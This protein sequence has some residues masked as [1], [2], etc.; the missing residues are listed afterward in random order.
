MISSNA[1]GHRTRR[2]AGQRTVALI[3]ATSLVLLAGCW[4]VSA[5]GAEPA[6]TSAAVMRTSTPAA[7]KKDC[8]SRTAAGVTSKQITVAATVIDLMGGSL[9]N[10]SYGIPSIADQEAGWK[11]V[12]DNINKNGGMGCRQIVLQLYTVNPIDSSAAQQVCLNIAAAHPFIV[13]DPGVLTEAN[14]SDCLPA[15]KVPLASEY[16][17][18]EQLD[19]YHPYYLQIGDL[20]EDILRNGVLGLKQL[21]YFE[22][23]KGFRKIGVLYHTC[24]TALETA[25]VGALKA[26]AIP[27]HDIV[28]YNLGCPN[29]GSDTPASMEQAVLN[30][31]NAGVT[32]VMMLEVTEG[33]IF[34]QVAEQQNFKPQYL[35]AEDDAATNVS[36]GGNAPNP[37]NYNNAVDVLGSAYGEQSTPGYKPSGGAQKC[38]ALLAAAGKPSVYSQTSGYPGVQC[39]Y[40]WFAQALLSHATTFEASAFPRD[41]RAMGTVDFSYPFAPT[42]FGA[43]P[44]DSTYGVD[45]WRAAIYHASCKCWQIPNAMFHPPFE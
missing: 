19:Q 26:A 2:V 10:A 4:A 28:D 32:D 45:F 18:E 11:M 44:A 1:T 37:A 8:P 7:A 12:A 23:S 30:F 29:G 36:T 40:L 5:T 17:S 31:K 15:H 42:D 41:M 16:L 38:N 35:H 33:G 20:P 9:N 6:K 3:L 14:A 27:S 39:D 43:A 24:S 34:T 25:E 13:L 22:A 21:G